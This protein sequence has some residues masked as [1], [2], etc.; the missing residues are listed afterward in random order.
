MWAFTSGLADL[1]FTYTKGGRSVDDCRRA[2]GRDIK[3]GDSGGVP[4]KVQLETIR[5]SGPVRRFTVETRSE[6]AARPFFRHFCSSARTSEPTLS[7]LTRLVTWQWVSG[8]SDAKTAS[9]PNRCNAAH[10]SARIL[11]L[12]DTAAPSSCSYPQPT[13]DGQ[14]RI[15]PDRTWFTRC[16]HVGNLPETI[17]FYLAWRGAG[18]LAPRS[19]GTVPGRTGPVPS[20][21]ARRGRTTG[22]KDEGRGTSDGLR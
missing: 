11:E 3:G 13:Y 7:W 2:R 6:Q 14:A 10:Y 17:G 15:G 12:S 18:C 1:T 21:G 22:S 9:P 5:S 20:V 16:I 19:E 4:S 8:A